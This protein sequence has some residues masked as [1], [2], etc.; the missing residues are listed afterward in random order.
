M[1]TAQF[2]PRALDVIADSG[3]CTDPVFRERPG[4]ATVAQ[5]DAA[6]AAELPLVSHLAYDSHAICKKFAANV[7]GRLAAIAAA[8]EGAV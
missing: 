6:V 7:R 1:N 8:T 5:F 4:A 3:E 2:T